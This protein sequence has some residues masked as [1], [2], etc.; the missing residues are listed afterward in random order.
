MNEK[1]E[2]QLS[3]AY[4]LTYAYD[5]KNKWMKSHQMSIHGKRDDIQRKD[6]LALA[7]KMNIK[8]PEDIIEQVLSAVSKW[9]KYSKAA[10]VDEE[11]AKRIFQYFNFLK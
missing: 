4:D 5:P 11:Q 6:V 10:E 1:S 7:K 9:K 8:H 2:W 3:P